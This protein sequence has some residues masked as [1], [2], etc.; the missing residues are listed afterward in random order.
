MFTTFDELTDQARIWIY[1]SDRQ[2]SSQEQHDILQQGQSFLSSWE[3]H[4]QP[5]K[6]S[7]KIFHD[8]FLVLAVEDEVHL[9]TGCS[10]DQ[11]VAF[12]KHLEAQLSLNFFNRQ[13]VS[14]WQHNSVMLKELTELK[15][16]IKAGQLDGETRIFNNLVATKGALEQWIVPIK[17]SW[18]ARYLPQ[19]ASNLGS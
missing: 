8:H 9:P 18:L 2:I 7:L 17:S 19:T 10:I 13:K 5:L 14:L 4:G 12:V 3:A 6:A 16:Q 1:Q 11:S 15:E